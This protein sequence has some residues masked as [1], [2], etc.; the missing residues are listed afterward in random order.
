MNAIVVSGDSRDQLDSLWHN[1]YYDRRKS[2]GVVNRRHL[3]VG[4]RRSNENAAHVAPNSYV[5]VYA[6]S[7]AIKAFLLV[8]LSTLDAMFTQIL[9]GAGAHELN[10]FVAYI[11]GSNSAFFVPIKVGVVPEPSP[12]L[13]FTNS[14]LDL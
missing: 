14:L 3:G 11:I 5:D 4:G 8:M 10:G 1:P 2:L 6:N 9:L 7:V 13:P 12:N